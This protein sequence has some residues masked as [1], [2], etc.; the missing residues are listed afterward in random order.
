MEL[1]WSRWTTLDPS[2]DAKTTPKEERI[3]HPEAAWKRAAV[4]FAH[5]GI[6]IGI[7]TAL[8]VA[9]NRYLRTFTIINP[10]KGRERQLF[11]QS[12][13]HTGSR[14]L[15]YPIS[16][17]H[18]QTG[19]NKGEIILRVDGERGHWFMST[20]NAFVFGKK[21]Q[22]ELDVKTMKKDERENWKR[23]CAFAVRHAIIKEW[24][25]A[26]KVGDWE[27]KE[28]ERHVLANKRMRA[29]ERLAATKRPVS[30]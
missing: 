5:A 7:G 14:G 18:L 29:M 27:E 9:R 26:K 1:T 19:R 24:G 13:A 25:P 6:G 4:C 21:P 17:C 22:D 23:E 28:L 30:S 2:Q 10:T 20:M 3:Y 11:I 15:L 12:A 16:R 8:I